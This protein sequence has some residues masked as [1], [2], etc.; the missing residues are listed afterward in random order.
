MRASKA[1]PQPKALPMVQQTAVEKCMVHGEDVI[2]LCLKDSEHICARCLHSTHLLHPVVPLGS[3]DQLDF[4]KSL[5]QEIETS[6]KE[7]QDR[8]PVLNQSICTSL[9]KHKINLRN[10]ILFIR[11]NLREEFDDFFNTL[12]QSIRKDWNLFTVQEQLIKQT[13]RFNEVVQKSLANIT[14]QA[15]MVEPKSDLKKFYEQLS[16]A[17]VQVQRHVEEWKAYEQ[18]V[19]SLMGCLRQHSAFDVIDGDCL[20]SF[21]QENLVMNYSNIEL[22]RV[23]I[24]QQQQF[25]GEDGAYSHANMRHNPRT[26]VQATRPRSPQQRQQQLVNSR[27][28]GSRS[29]FSGNNSR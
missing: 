5:K 3:L 17:Q 23:L 18:S 16:D 25:E 7:I 14:E 2:L 27:N 11:D 20:K 9:R 13:R 22:N 26:T 10:H 29:G 1:G 12:L 15:L 21:M 6:L 8:E 4:Q 24:Q 19:Q 28:A